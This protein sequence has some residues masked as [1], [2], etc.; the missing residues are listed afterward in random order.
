[1][2]FVSAVLLRKRFED[3]CMIAA[4][5]LETMRTHL[6]NR[7]FMSVEQERAEDFSRER[8]E[9]GNDFFKIDRNL[10]NERIRGDADMFLRV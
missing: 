10:R 4:V 9:G 2:P 3:V 7:S 1:M 5:K 6:F 8:E